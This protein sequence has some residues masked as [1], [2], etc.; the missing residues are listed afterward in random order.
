MMF[1]EM[2]VMDSESYMKPINALRE[3]C[4]VIDCFSRFLHTASTVLNDLICVRSLH[5]LTRYH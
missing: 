2:I 1:Q 5:L 3:E 4:S